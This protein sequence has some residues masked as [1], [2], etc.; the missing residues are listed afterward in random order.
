VTAALLQMADGEVR[1]G[2]CGTVFNALHTLVDD[3][4]GPDSALPGEPRLTHPDAGE[5]AAAPS[6]TLEFDVPENDWQR[7]F[8]Q[9][10]APPAPEASTGAEPEAS[11]D[12]D[13]PPD[14]E[15][16]GESATDSDDTRD[17]PAPNLSLEDETSDTDTWRAFLRE[18]Q[19]DEEPP[20]VIGEDAACDDGI[21]I[22]RP[23]DG[24]APPVAG[25]ARPGGECAE[26]DAADAGLLDTA[27][28]EVLGAQDRGGLPAESVL[29]WGPPPA[30]AERAP[31]APA[32]SARWFAA[33]VVAAALLGGQAM[34]Y[35]RDA[36]AAD[37]SYGALI[38]Q[39]Y[40]QLDQPVYPAWPLD[41]YEIRDTKAIAERSA[42]GA[43][44][45]V[46]EIAVTGR[47]AVGPPMVRVVLRDR[48]S[49]AIAS[50]V[51]SPDQ[52]LAEPQPESQTHPPGTLIPVEIS[53]KDPGAAAQGYEL[54]VCIPNRK[55]GLQCKTARA[56]FRR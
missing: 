52:Y 54:D 47:Q 5:P 44:D 46:A 35:F 14:G 43:L 27:S 48:W 56:P 18:A 30:F 21:L 6:Q 20:Y 9:E 51:F 55:A 13:G 31:Q 22:R 41:A 50:G 4:S 37:P 15:A 24:G 34:H 49:N 40:G 19:P 33:S 7:F 28:P 32:H 45:I 12:Q 3:W 25:S 16:G 29:D 26:A 39:L 17:Q 42:P 1:C 23:P 10:E 2:S 11:A 36:L 53:L 38:R 8:I